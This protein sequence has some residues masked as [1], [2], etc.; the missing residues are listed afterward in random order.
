[1]K[2][3]LALLVSAAFALSSVGFAVAQDK[4]MEDKKMDDKKMEK[5]EKGAKKSSKGDKKMDDKK[6]EKK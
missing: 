3:M 1:M 6:E 4:K 2:K 5:T